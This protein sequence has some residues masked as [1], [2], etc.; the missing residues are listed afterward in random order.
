MRLIQDECVG[1]KT[2]E[3]HKPD[4]RQYKVLIKPNQI[5]FPQLQSETNFYFFYFLIDN[6]T[7][8]ELSYRSTFTSVR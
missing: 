3:I 7:P 6:E 2:I 1:I 4:S 5:T 8:F